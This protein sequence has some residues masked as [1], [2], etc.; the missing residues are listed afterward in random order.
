[1]VSKKRV[2]ATILHALIPIIGVV[3]SL[4]YAI[5][6]HE[7]APHI[8]LIFGS[9]I[10]AVVAVTMLGIPWEELEQGIKDTL[11][12]TLQAILILMI[13]GTLIGLWILS[14]TIPAMIY[15]GLQILSP[16]VFLAATFVI[17]CIV[18]LATGTSWGT[19]GTVGI[20]LTGIG[21]GLG[22]PAGMVAGAVVSGA[23]F[24]DKLS[25]LSD[26]TNLAPAMAGSS[27]FPHIK[28]MLYTSIPAFVISLVLYIILGLRFAGRELD[29]ERINV[30]LDA[31]RTNF[32]ISPWLLIPPVIVI[33]LIAFKVP[34]LPGLIGGSVAGGLFAAIFQSASVGAI[35][36]AAHYGFEI[37]SGVAVVDRLLNRGGLDGMMWTVALIICALVFGGMLEKTGMLRA[38]G[39]KLFAMAKSNGSLVLSTII[40]CIAV[41]ILAADQYLSI[42]LPGRLFK[43]EYAR[44]GLAPKNLSRALEGGGTVTSALIP[45]NTCGAFMMVTLGVSPLAYLPYAFLNLLLPVINVVY[46]YLGFSMAKLADE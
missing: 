5:L 27:L 41:N 45:W 28:H 1:M 9:I 37:D 18:S 26:T 2:E 14:G 42:V 43:D 8:P 40:S 20:A 3:A 46:G 13:V 16:G 36:T 32:A 29:A 38:I 11:S 4:S 10:A 30:I 15:Y 44:R 22:M 33:L 6:V 39:V 24:G 34:A 31:L 17:C 21:I 23:Y 7:A 19:A 12:S 25:P 35:I